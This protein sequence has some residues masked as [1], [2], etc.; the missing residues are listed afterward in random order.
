MM[1]ICWECQRS[2]EAVYR[3]ANLPDEKKSKQVKCQEAHLEVVHI[4]RSLCNNMVH[5]VKV[6]A[7]KRTL[8]LLD[9]KQLV[10]TLKCIT[11]SIMLSKYITQVTRYNRVQCTSWFHRSAV[12]LEC[13]A[14]LFHSR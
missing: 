6:V 3:S 13:V 8:Q 1:D 12:F 4:E 7:Q 10:K 14:R 2:N 11:A 5:E 9:R